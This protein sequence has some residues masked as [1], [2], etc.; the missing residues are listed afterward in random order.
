MTLQKLLMTLF[1]CAVMHERPVAAHLRVWLLHNK[2][3]GPNKT[4][5]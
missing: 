2:S 5:E 1:D 3:A 4:L